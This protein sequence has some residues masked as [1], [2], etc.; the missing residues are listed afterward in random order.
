MFWNHQVDER[1]RET[2]PGEGRRKEK[3]ERERMG[4]KIG[5]A[6]VE[7]L[8]ILLD[9]LSSNGQKKEKNKPDNTSIN[10]M[11]LA[12]ILLHLAGVLVAFD[13]T[14]ENY[15]VPISGK[16]VLTCYVAEV[17]SFKV[18]RCWFFG[19]EIDR[20]GDTICWFNKPFRVLSQSSHRIRDRLIRL[21]SFV[22]VGSFDAVTER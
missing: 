11:W 12:C 4:E 17:R 15:T 21:I 1:E 3:R 13:T 14:A 18:S 9:T 6:V 7:W 8:S 16:C 10:A 5:L 19:S 20:L 22:L 2:R